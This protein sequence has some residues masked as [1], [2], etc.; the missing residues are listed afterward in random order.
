MLEIHIPKAKGGWY[1]GKPLFTSLLSV[2]CPSLGGMM[3]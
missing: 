1:I 2:M 3:E